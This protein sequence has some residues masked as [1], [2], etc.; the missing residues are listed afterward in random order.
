MAV[1]WCLWPGS[2]GN[3]NVRGKDWGIMAIANLH[4][5]SVVAVGRRR[6]WAGGS[7]IEE[8]QL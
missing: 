6:R 7:G 4:Q 3:S 8:A 5:V 2:G 1:G